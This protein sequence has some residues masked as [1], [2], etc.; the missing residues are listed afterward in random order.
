MVLFV[1]RHITGAGI[2]L[3]EI[4]P[5]DIK[6]VPKDTCHYKTDKQNPNIMDAGCIGA[7]IVVQEDFHYCTFCGRAIEKDPPLKPRTVA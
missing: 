1:M 4:M 7:W 5:F 2:I 6:G 3:E